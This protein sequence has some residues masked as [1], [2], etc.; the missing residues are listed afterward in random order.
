MKYKTVMIPISIYEKLKEYKEKEGF[1][2]LIA[3]L[4]FII[5]KEVDKNG[6][7]Q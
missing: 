4:S 7:N 6:K 3:A 5:K 2:S 1:S